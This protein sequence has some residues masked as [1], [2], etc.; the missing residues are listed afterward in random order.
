MMISRISWSIFMFSL[1]IGCKSNVSGNID[2]SKT[3]SDDG[4]K[5]YD[6]TSTK[7]PMDPIVPKIVTE[8]V[9]ERVPIVKSKLGY[10]PLVTSRI[11]FE[12]GLEGTI[13]ER[14]NDCEQ[15]KPESADKVKVTI[16]DTRNSN[17]EEKLYSWSLVT[18]IS[19]S[20]DDFYQVWL[21]N[22]TNLLWSDKYGGSSAFNA[23]WCK[24]SGSSNKNS[25][26]LSEA[27]VDK[28]CSS[29]E[30]QNQ[31]AP[32]SYC[33]EDLQNLSGKL[34]LSKGRSITKNFA[35]GN[36]GQDEKKGKITWWLPTIDQFREAQLHGADLVLPNFNNERNS[37][38]W[39]SSID[40]TKLKSQEK[41]ALIFKGDTGS[42]LAKSRREE[43]SIRCVGKAE[44]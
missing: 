1:T 22:K 13:K 38:F 31:K 39:T 41:L 43:Y 15:N 25:S 18:S 34:T 14:I 37:W 7:V 12:C 8:G 28:I 35:K 20:S 44:D 42:T 27:D 2:E 29:D 6:K 16:E 26:P 5:L 9:T 40:N 17:L 32:Q 33:A 21:D 10:I 11:A 4:P 19:S 24:A 23:N 3:T 30:F 36:L